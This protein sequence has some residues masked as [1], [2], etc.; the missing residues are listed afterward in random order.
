MTID[1]VIATFLGMAL[2]SLINGIVNRDKIVI[3]GESVT[4]AIIFVLVA[5]VIKVIYGG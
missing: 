4:K 1:F 2:N 3:L 5:F